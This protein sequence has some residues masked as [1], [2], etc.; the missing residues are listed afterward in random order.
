MKSE[1]QYKGNGEQVQCP[2]CGYKWVYTGDKKHYISCPDCRANIN[3]PKLREGE[4][5]PAK[6]T[7]G[8]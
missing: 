6:K 4:R 3:L 5:K 8:K 1:M 7:V 2:K